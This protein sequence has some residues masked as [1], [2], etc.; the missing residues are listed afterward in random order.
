MGQDKKITAAVLSG[1][2]DRNIGFTDL[3]NLLVGLGFS[4]RIKGD[5]HIFTRPDVV[6]IIN[7]QPDGDKAKPYQV[8][9]VRSLIVKY[10]LGGEL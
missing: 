9:Q 1:M 8:R 10:K 6:E 7:L 2:Q 4:V 5:H 3:Y